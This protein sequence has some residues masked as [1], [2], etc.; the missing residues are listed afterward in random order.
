MSL[1][2]GAVAWPS[3]FSSARSATQRSM[4]TSACSVKSGIVALD[5][6]IRLAIVRWR[7]DSSQVVVSPFALATSSP[8]VVSPLAPAT[9]LTGGVDG[10]CGGAG[11]SAGA[12]SVVAACTSALTIRPPGPLPMSVCRST[13]DS[14][15]IRLARGDALTRSPPRGVVGAGDIGEVD[16]GWVG[17]AGDGGAL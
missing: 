8:V 6:A 15:A 1:Y 13:P 11:A 4:S 16:N 9:S 12:G 3:P 14:L 7:R 17:N 10:G 2:V 5:S